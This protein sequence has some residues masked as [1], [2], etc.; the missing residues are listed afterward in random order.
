[1]RKRNL[2]WLTV[3]TLLALSA[4]L[5]LSTGCQTARAIGQQVRATLEPPIEKADTLVGVVARQAYEINDIAT[6]LALGQ[7]VTEA[8]KAK[9]LKLTGDVSMAT[10]AAKSSTQDALYWIRL[11]PE[12]EAKQ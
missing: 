1:M 11:L 7:P 9:L 8:E 10:A 6:R 2:S 12:P 5:S 3:L 4:T